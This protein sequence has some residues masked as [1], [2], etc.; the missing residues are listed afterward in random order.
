MKYNKEK[1]IIT[2]MICLSILTVF[3]DVSWGIYFAVM[4]NVL[5]N[6]FGHYTK[7]YIDGQ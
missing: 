5:T 1:K 3:I 4:T 2:F 7:H 6:Y